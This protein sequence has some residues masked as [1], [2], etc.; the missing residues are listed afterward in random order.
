M[1][2]VTLDVK[3]GVIGSGNAIKSARKKLEQMVAENIKQLIER[4]LKEEKNG[5]NNVGE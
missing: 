1:A 5:Y 2:E 4:G 3:D